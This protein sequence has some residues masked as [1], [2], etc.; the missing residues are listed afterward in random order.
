MKKWKI[1]KSKIGIFVLCT[2]CVSCATIG[3][4]F[5]AN[6]LNVEGDGKF[7]VTKNAYGKMDDKNGLLLTSNGNFASYLLAEKASDVFEVEARAL[8]SKEGESDFTTLTFSIVDESTQMGLDIAVEESYSGE[9]R[10]Y[11]LNVTPTHVE[12][13]VGKTYSNANVVTGYYAFDET[14]ETMRFGYDIYEKEVFYYKEGNRAVLLDLDDKISLGHMSTNIVFPEFSTYSV[15]VKMDGLKEETASCLLYSFNGQSLGGETFTNTAGAVVCGEL[16]LNNG[17]V[18]KEFT[19]PASALTTYDVLDGFRD[20]VDGRVKVVDPDGKTTEIENY[21]FIPEAAGNYVLEVSAKDSQGRYGTNRYFDFYVYGVEP[22]TEISTAYSLSDVTIGRAGKLYLPSATASSL[23]TLNGDTPNLT[24][25][26]KKNGST[27]ATL[28]CNAMNEYEFTEEGAYTV[29][30]LAEN[31]YGTTKSLIYAVTVSADVPAF[32]LESSISQNYDLNSVFVLPTAT[33]KGVEASAK[34]IYPS[35]STTTAGVVKLDE[36]GEYAVTYTATVDGTEYAYTRNF[37]VRTKSADLFKNVKGV[38][39][40]NYATTPKYTA[41]KATGVKIVGVRENATVRTANPINITDNTV[42]DNIAKFLFTPEMEGNHEF[43]HFV[44]TLTD[45]NDE[46][47]F[48]QIRYERGTLGEGQIVTAKARTNEMSDFI[49]RGGSQSVKGIFS[50]TFTHK[51]FGKFPSMY[52]SLNCDNATHTVYS[53]VSNAAAEYNRKAVCLTDESMVGIG[54][55]FE[56]FP[57]GFAYVSF[58]F[59]KVVAAKANVMLMELDGQDLT[60]EYVKDTTA[61]N[62]SVDY[63]EYEENQ[64]PEGAVDKKYPIFSASAIDFVDG[65]RPYTAKVYFLE[66]GQEVRYYDYDEAGF[67]P[68]RAG[69]YV[70][71]YAAADNSGN[72]IEKRVL[73]EVKG[74]LEE[75]G[76]EVNMPTQGAQGRSFAIPEGIATGGSGNISVSTRVTQ[77]SDEIAL[78]EGGFIPKKAGEY[79]VTVTLK[80]FLGAEKEFEYTV[81][82][83]ES[84]APIFEERNLPNVVVVGKE[85]TFANWTAYDYADG[86]ERTVPVTIKVNGTA[87]GEDCK[88]TPSEPGSYTVEF[89]AENAQG[90]ATEERT[91]QAVSL[92]REENFIANYFHLENMAVGEEASYTYLPLVATGAGAKATFVNPLSVNGFELNFSPNKEKNGYDGIRVLIQDIANLNQKIVI[93]IMKSS[94]E[95]SVNSLLTINGVEGQLQGSFYA[96]SNVP[97]VLN[98]DYQTHAFADYSGK[99]V[100]YA[101]NADGTAWTGF[102]SGMVYVSY[103]LINPVANEA[104]LHLGGIANHTLGVSASKDGVAPYITMGAINKVVE[105]GDTVTLAPAFAFDV[106]GDVASFTMSL[107]TPS[108]KLLLTEN[109]PTKVSTF[110][111]D[112]YG[113]YTLTYKAVDGN[114]KSKQITFNINVFYNVKPTLSYSGEMS[115]T[116]KAGKSVTLPK[117]TVGGTNEATKLSVYIMQPNG[118]RVKVEGDSVTF[119]QK[120][121]NKLTHRFF[122]F[123]HNETGWAGHGTAYDSFG[124]CDKPRLD[125]DFRHVGLM[126]SDDEGK[127]WEF[128][129][130][131]LSGELA[132]F[133]EKYN[134]GAG[135]MLGQK[136]GRINLGSGDFSAY[137]EED[138]EYIYLFY[139]IM[140]VNIQTN[141]VEDID[142]FVARTRKRSDGVMG[143]FVK[144]YNGSFCEAGNFGKETPIVKG[145]WHAK[146]LKL[147]DEEIYV[148]TSSGVNPNTYHDPANG[149]I[150]IKHQLQIH[151]STD[152]IHWSEPIYLSKDGKA[153]GAHYCAFYPD[154]ETNTFEVE[155]NKFIC[156]L[157]GNGTS[158]TAYDVEF[159]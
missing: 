10:K 67:T 9:T 7:T 130:W 114:G 158:V 60:G 25:T 1:F 120:G 151:T 77:G 100:G 157:G 93:E 5:L 2:A 116:A 22:E 106:L 65:V 148:M 40:E 107:K 147:K 84:T 79:V 140:Y 20:G 47:I 29:E 71:L 43:E 6:A 154:D 49:N 13:T 115:T 72:V 104:I 64:L 110:K 76:Y 141:I 14:G 27:V 35:G 89:S 18:G 111:V 118:S 138:G 73:V 135:N 11:A 69:E 36:A 95:T 150:L 123:F 124:L 152:L 12:R 70:I 48:V 117:I 57:S 21:S 122:A 59:E 66:N 90:I 74:S 155:G 98:Y 102:D 78:T 37:S 39:I 45:A 144:Y 56:G 129:R 97:F 42:N 87:L 75:L 34:I 61:P 139:N 108:G 146:V 53:S 131:V 86:E 119:T 51:T 52:V 41:E 149:K 62:I 80:D 50:G 96:G 153:F 159:K 136:E 137:I 33:A 3:G 156:Q 23:L 81:S 113:S 83:A 145:A 26:V 132:C 44:I 28:N 101:R 121:L 55:K 128:D 68:D 54:N 134:P 16:A 127:T 143:D 112:E 15:S 17:V 30:Y 91:I 133:T 63:G 58:S 103:E 85:F 92:T 105:F 125:S 38:K 109:D 46:N 94:D 99:I 4:V 31:V 88:W 19:V 8:S 82:I 142:V 126:H 32:A 24:L